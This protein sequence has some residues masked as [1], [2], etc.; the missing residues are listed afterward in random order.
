MRSHNDGGK[1]ALPMLAVPSLAGLVTMVVLLMADPRPHWTVLV[2]SAVFASLAIVTGRPR[3]VLG[4]LVGRMGWTA[5]P[6]FVVLV[7]FVSAEGFGLTIF[8]VAAG[9]FAGRWIMWDEG[10]LRDWQIGCGVAGS[11]LLAVMLLALGAGVVPSML[12]AGWV[13]AMLRADMAGERLDEIMR[14]PVMAGICLLLAVALIAAVIA[15]ALHPVAGWMVA[16]P[17]G[18]WLLV[19][20]LGGPVAGGRVAVDPVRSN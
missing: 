2:L 20:W 4:R 6:L 19:P 7:S 12:F 1:A 5:F 9:L 11:I 3:D 17:A 15:G 14:R 10:P 13:L 18:R 16:V 8:A